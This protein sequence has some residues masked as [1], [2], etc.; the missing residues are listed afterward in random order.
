MAHP[1]RLA[2][3]VLVAL[4]GMATPNRSS[5]QSPPEPRIEPMPDSG[6]IARPV[7]QT[8]AMIIPDSIAPAPITSFSELLQGRVPGLTVER[9]NG[10]L[11]AASDVR[12]RG[13]NSLLFTA[14]PLVIVDGIRVD[15]VTGS[16]GSKV[17]KPTS[18]LDDLQPED[19]ERIEVLNGP[20]AAWRYGHGAANGVLLVTTKDGRPGHLHWRTH[21]SLGGSTVTTAFPTNYAQIGV[22]TDGTRLLRCTLLQQLAGD[23]TPIADS[24]L[25]FNP[26][27]ERSPFTTGRRTDVGVSASGGGRRGTF[28]AGSDLATD[29]GTFDLNDLHRATLRA[30]GTV[31]L[32]PNLDLQLRT[33]YLA[34]TLDLPLAID[35][36]DRLLWTG[37]LRGPSTTNPDSEFAVTVDTIRQSHSAQDVDHLTL[38]GSAT[39]S[40]VQWLSTTA[41]LGA[42]R[43]H[44]R[45]E[46]RFP[47][48]PGIVSRS[49]LDEWRRMLTARF[50]TRAAWHASTSLRLGSALEIEQVRDD[51][52]SR[53]EAFLS[54]DGLESESKRS[55]RL[56]S[57]LTGILARA[58]VTWNDRLALTGG[59]RRDH[60][61]YDDVP[62]TFA[63]T[64]PAVALS[65]IASDEPWFPRSTVQT[66]TLRA[67][68]G[69][70]GQPTRLRAGRAGVLPPDL[71]SLLP[72]TLP[73][74]P[75]HSREMELGINAGLLD[76]RLGIGLTYYRRTAGDV[77]FFAPTPPGSGAPEFELTTVGQIRNS[78]LETSVDLTLAR[79]DELDWH[80]SAISTFPRT[81]FLAPGPRPPVLFVSQRIQNYSPNVQQVRNGYP[82]GGYWGRP[83]LGY[84]DR[85][86]DGLIGPTEVEF[87]DTAVYLGSPYPTRT[88]SLASR[89]GIR[90]R[91][92]VSAL[93]DYRGGQKLYDGT[94]ENRCTHSLCRETEDPTA[95]LAD[96]ARYVAR[97]YSLDLTGYIEDATYWRL[98]EVS[99][100]L[101]APARWAARIGASR[102][103]L[104]LA[105]RNLA[106]WTRYTGLDPEVNAAGPDALDQLELVTIP[107]PR[108]ILTRLDVTW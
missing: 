46:H 71:D 51:E 88:L 27:E 96:Q 9:S 89:L 93:L 84:A 95:P 31:H 65:W 92:I 53:S 91:V 83:I 7:R 90:R 2:P 75:E 47:N 8:G 3:A 19:I 38:G 99:F 6:A 105:G 20:A 10:F 14:D 12:L 1:P 25:R 101:V 21:A 4:I 76:A 61:S 67:A 56:R 28:Y 32:R 44:A 77:V 11:D 30:N 41:T 73:I 68:Y 50:A 98:R 40:I 66:L 60:L 69:E 94:T 72:P 48:P 37:L 104:T 54:A 39:W 18:R 82:V 97:R 43:F 62:T 103:V 58:E 49:S 78:G 16:I 34:G 100:Q 107:L 17:W 45:S 81:R 80:L 55:L 70:A 108:T 64:Y 86:G 52:R 74:E 59:V 26:L 106:T 22:R 36:V 33:G 13:P 5:A 57:T 29:R 15:A 24:L 23:C 102:L 35:G 63:R 85:D 42:D 87:G 79:G